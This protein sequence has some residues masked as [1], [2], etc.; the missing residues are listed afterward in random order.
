MCMYHVRLFVKFYETFVT[1]CLEKRK[2]EKE[3]ERKEKNQKKKEKKKY[4]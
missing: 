3:E 1:I 2:K 4:I